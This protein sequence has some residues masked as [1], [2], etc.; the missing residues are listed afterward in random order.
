MKDW[1][2]EKGATHYTHWFQPL[3]GLTAEKH[4][5]FLSPDGDGK[6]IAEFTRQGAD[7]GRARRVELPVRRHAR[8]L[9]GPRLHGLG[10]DQPGLHPRDA[11]RHDALHPDRV[12]RWTGE[13]LDKKTPLLR[14]M[15]ALSTQALALL[16]LFGDDGAQR[17]FA[18]RRPRA[19]ILP[20]R[21]ST[22]TLRA[23]PHHR[24]PHARSA[25]RRRRARSSRTTTSARSRS[26]SWPAWSR[27]STSST[28]SACRSRRATTRSRPRQYEIAPIFENANV[29]ADH[30]SSTWR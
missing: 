9:R 11:Q 25:R 4:D 5:T 3:T 17:V 28:S 2:I 14:S 7:P 10:P 6:A 16:E 13:A 19:G 20:D 26:A 30:N 15:E 29:A 8:D 21:Q 23:R 27:S 18:T 24:R 12:R 1:A 22:S